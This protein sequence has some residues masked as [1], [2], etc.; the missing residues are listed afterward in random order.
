MDPAQLANESAAA[1]L[2]INLGLILLAGCGAGGLL[3]MLIRGL[4]ATALPELGRR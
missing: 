2:L 4:R 3:A 1:A